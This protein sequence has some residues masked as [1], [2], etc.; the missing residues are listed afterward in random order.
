IVNS[1]EQAALLGDARW[2]ELPV[3]HEQMLR[4]EV[5]AA[6]GRVVKLIGDGS[7]STCAG[8]ARAIR[9]AERLRTA[10]E[11]R[12]LAIRAGLH[13]GECELIG[14]NVAGIAVHIA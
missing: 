2:R 14:G 13:T 10:A 6:G 9:C 11:E 7:L 4:R 12:E 8:R 1:T 5:E 3:T